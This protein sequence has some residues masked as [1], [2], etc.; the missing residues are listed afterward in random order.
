ML[1]FNIND[2][3]NLDKLSEIIGLNE[4][5]IDLNYIN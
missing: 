5:I 2:R 4:K 1:K 3:I